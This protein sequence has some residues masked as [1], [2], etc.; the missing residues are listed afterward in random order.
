MS[1]STKLGWRIAQRE[2]RHELRGGLRGFRVFLA[3]L[4]LGVASIAA[5]GTLREGIRAGLADQ[6]AVILGGDAELRFTYRTATEAEREW[7]DAQAVR[8][9]EVT[10]FRSM[11]GVGEERVLT[12]VKAVDQQYPLYGDPVLEPEIALETALAPQ[13]GVPSAVMDPVLAD[14]MGLAIGDRFALGATEFRL[15]ARLI[16]EPDSAGAG[17]GLGPRTLV[18]KI[19]LEGSGLLSAGAMFETDYKLAL[20]AGTDLEAAKT[21]AETEFE[22]T[23]IR[24]RDSRRAAG[25]VERFVNRISSFLVLVGL[26]GL[27]V[28]GVGIAQAVRA[29]A[30]RKTETIATLK[31]VGAGTGLIRAVFMTQVAVMGVIGIGLGVAL[32]AGI[33]VLLSR[34]IASA[35]PFPADSGFAPRAAIEAGI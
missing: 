26:A 16:R 3:C 4:I 28:G 6:G 21:A 22:G 27:A 10:E 25:G 5:I 34:P 11:A 32:G 19:D 8:V 17:I 24:W 15:S 7:I 2:M 1:H 12:Q 29:W 35:L 13:N 20:P 9:A 14:R 30:E 33:P 23:G 18:R 31:A